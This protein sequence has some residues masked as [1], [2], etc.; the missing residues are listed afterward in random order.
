MD[1][2]EF[3]QTFKEEI[4]LIFLKLFHEIERKGTLPKSLYKA[5]LK[6]ENDR[7]ISLMNIDVTILNKIMA[8]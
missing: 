7:L 1:S 3:Y 6:K 4:I 2:H 5:T 8:N